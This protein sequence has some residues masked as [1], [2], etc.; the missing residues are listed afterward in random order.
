MSRAPE[1]AAA[2]GRLLATLAR[3]QT[4]YAESPE[5]DFDELETVEAYMYA[6]QM[7]GHVSEF[8]IEADRERPR[9][10][11]IV[12][13]ARKLL[14]DNPDSIYH[15]AAIRGDRAYRIKGR[16]TGQDYI[17]FTVHGTDPTGG[18]G[19]PVLADINDS[20]F[21]FD[22]DDRYELVLGATEPPAD[23]PAVWV[24]LDADA[25]MVLVRNYFQ[26]ERSAHNDPEV[27]V[28]LDI[29]P[30]APNGPSP[31]LT[32]AEV[33]GRIEQ[34]CAMLEAIT[35]GVRVFGAP[36]AHPVPFV[37]EVPN[38][39]GTPWSFRATGEA[40]AGAVDIHYSSG[41]W[42][43][44]PDDALVMEGT[45]PPSRFTNVVLWNV[46]MGTVDYRTRTTALS[47]AQIAPEADGSYR[48]VISAQDPGVPNWLDTGGHRRGTIFWRFLLPESQP[49]T[50]RCTVVPVSS[51]R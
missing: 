45:I 30:L 35:M 11:L 27:H 34:S 33:A 41:A 17:S 20:D 38:T 21:R 3:I 8:L 23:D 13:P 36:P 19:G 49:E 5:R 32:D 44:G 1:T 12:S 18:F 37:S 16:R 14:G 7:V 51:L 10:S 22:A 46:H 6:I 9:F 48:I 50:P 4:D 26:H 39:V 24:P 40:V 2:Y 29:E 31:V 47:Q 28:V 25:R 42:D 15:Q 43:L